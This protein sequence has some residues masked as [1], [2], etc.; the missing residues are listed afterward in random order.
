MEAPA[1]HGFEHAVH[2]SEL[3]G[4]VLMIVCVWALWAAHRDKKNPINL[5]GAFV[6]PGTKQT[7]IALLLAWIGGIASTWIVIHAELKGTLSET[8]FTAYLGI[9]V[10][11]KAATEGINAWRSRQ[12][13]PPGTSSQKTVQS[14]E[15][16]SVSSPQSGNG[17]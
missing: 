15:T 1:S 12:P 7:S 10:L 4:L 14:V 11:G 2:G 16:T 6:W 5:A 9:I 8:I 3:V 17:S 13:V